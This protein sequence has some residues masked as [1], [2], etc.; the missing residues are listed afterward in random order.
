MSARYPEASMA[1]RLMTEAQ[2]QRK[3]TDYARLKGWRWY[4]THDSRRSNHGFPDL[5]LVRAGRLI[6]AELKSEAGRVTPAQQ[7]WLNDLTEAIGAVYL[8]RPSDWPEVLEVLA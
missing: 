7:A 4:H 5:V 1:D 6:F 2:W 8:W 3:V